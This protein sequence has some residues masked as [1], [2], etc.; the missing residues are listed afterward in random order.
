MDTS[1]SRLPLSRVLA[2]A[3][4]GMP[5]GAVGLPMAVFVAPM[6]ADELG[7]GTAIVGLVF[8]FLRFW[9]LITDPIMGWLVDTR[10]LRNGR[11]KHWLLASVPVLMLGSIFVYIPFGDTGNAIYLAFW[12]TILWLGYTMLQ[13]PHQAWVPLITDNY[14]ERSRFFMWLEIVSTATVL[15][16]LF[17]PVILAM[18]YGLDR[19][20]QVMVMGII[21]AVV[22]PLTVA[23]ATRFVPDAPPKPTD[24]PVSYS[25][26]IVKRAL[27]D[28]AV[29]RIVAVYI[30]VGVAISATGATFLFAAQWGFG[31]EDAATAI[32]AVYFIAGFAAMPFWTWLSERT[33]K[34]IALIG[35]SIWSV[36]S[37]L[38]YIPLSEAGGGWL[39]LTIAAIITGLAYGPPFILLRSMMADVIEQTR[40][41]SGEARAGLYYAILSGA[42]KMGAA[43]AVG[44]PYILLEW[45]VGF[46][47]NG[48]NAPEVV[49]GVMLVFVGVPVAAY[50]LAAIICRGYP[51]TRQVQREAAEKL[52][53]G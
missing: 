5:L 53:R 38:I 4:I 47:A 30:L 18:T 1:N 27:F 35:V 23:L 9:D 17:I 21:L 8:M 7:L 19:R 2:Y 52:S 16:L 51:I 22:L 12:M 43:L 33:E 14:D 29:V 37:Y 20:D 49:R 42:Y 24:K 25:W 31:V 40:A 11:V 45:L 10:P 36:F 6:Y 41:E 50:A 32:L 39:A 15:G 34:H 44:I 13:T 28:P 48:D 26:P 46:N 3:S